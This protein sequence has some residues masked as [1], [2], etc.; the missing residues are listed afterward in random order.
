MNLWPHE[1]DKANLGHEILDQKPPMWDFVW[2]L[3][4]QKSLDAKLEATSITPCFF[5]CQAVSAA[6]EWNN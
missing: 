5:L 2:Q 4:S 3:R 6:A 1:E